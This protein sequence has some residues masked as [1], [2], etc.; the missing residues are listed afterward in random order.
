[1]DDIIVDNN[2]HPTNVIIVRGDRG[3]P[4]LPLLLLWKQVHE[5]T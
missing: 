3:H 1:M 2:G 4:K 5:G